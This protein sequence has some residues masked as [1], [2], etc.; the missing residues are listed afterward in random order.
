VPTVNA[1]S[2]MVF[3]PSNPFAATQPSQTMPT[4]TS[5][6]MPTSTSTDPFEDLFR[7]AI[8]MPLSRRITPSPTH[9]NSPTPEIPDRPANSTA[10]L[11]KPQGSNP[12]LWIPPPPKGPPPSLPAMPKVYKK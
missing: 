11:P 5:Q 9:G 2:P 7:S 6:L 4:T 12:I 10:S 3:S 8:N 1:P